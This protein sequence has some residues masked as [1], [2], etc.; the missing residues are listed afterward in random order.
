MIQKHSKNPNSKG[1]SPF[2]ER[3]EHKVILHLNK[4]KEPGTSSSGL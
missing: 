3:K 2:K 4:E 1:L